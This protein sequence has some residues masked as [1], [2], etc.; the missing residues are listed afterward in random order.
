M[1]LDRVAVLGA[2]NA[3]HAAAGD[4]ALAG[5]KVN[6]YE[7]PEYEQN[8]K[9]VRERGG[10]E[11]TGVV[12]QGFARLNL[13]TS[14][15]AE[16]IRDVEHILVVTQALAHE[17]LA[18]LCAPCVHP[19]QTI[20]LMPGSG[21][22]LVFGKALRGKKV[23]MAETVTLPYACRVVGPAHV[24]IHAG[25]GRREVIG[26]FPAVETLRV[27]EELREIYPSL[28]PAEHVLEVA[29]YN[30]NVLLHPTGTMFNLGRIEHSGG[31]FWM[32]KEGFTPSVWKI[33]EGLDAEKMGLLQA[34]GLKAI[35]YL[36]HY[37]WRY[38][39][40]WSDFAAVSSKGPFSADTRYITEDVPMGL[41]LWASL[42]DLLGVPTPTVKAIIQIASTI[43]NRNFWDQG[44]T[45]DRLGLS[46]MNREQLKEYLKTGN[47]WVTSSEDSLSTPASG[48]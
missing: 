41:V 23:I 47:G 24:H 1:S 10:I 16:A 7:L 32:Y 31:E 48:G 39:G 3:G 9:P 44:R 46:E 20:T 15:I 26:A 43:H 45:M 25:P 27:V 4:L 6:L 12:R 29:L 33:V 35:P 19:G 14:D 18:A 22:S 13:I 40:T 37:E 34:L 8:L 38:G 36:A 11:V 17:R 30:P 21:G 2:G 5:L 42:G 28:V